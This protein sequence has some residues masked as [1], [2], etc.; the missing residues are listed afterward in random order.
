MKRCTE[1]VFSLALLGVLGIATSQCVT[2]HEALEKK[3][4]GSGGV[5]G[6]GSGGKG[7]S[8]SS[9]GTTTTGGSGGSGG[10]YVD[11]PG[12]NVVTFVHG[13]VDEE[14]IAFCFAHD[15]DGVAE[16][17]GSPLPEGGLDYAHSFSLEALDGF[18][19][20]AEAIQP[21]VLGGDLTEYAGLDCAAAVAKA[22]QA[23]ND[24]L[25]EPS[26]VA[27]APA[28]AG[29][30]G[31]AGGDP[32]PSTGGTPGSGG[33]PA[34]PDAP[35][36]RGRALPALPA[37]TLS[38]GLSYL[39][40]AAGCVGGPWFVDA[41]D[42]N[43]CGADYEGQSTL[44]PILVSMSR[45]TTLRLGLQGVHAS[46]ASGQLDL[47]VTPPDTGVDSP[48]VVAPDLVEG[49]I[50]PRPA[51][52]T[53]FRS[54]LGVGDSAFNLELVSDGSAVLSEPW[55]VVLNRGDLDDAVDGENYVIVALGPK[56]GLGLTKWWNAPA[57][58]IVKSDP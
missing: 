2:D 28:S 26:G 49:V 41:E 56:A 45:E 42:D 24:A 40:V 25:P 11:T 51:E 44:V 30:A 23:M 6:G 39:F 20:G 12:R 10:K 57:L 46:R 54:E 7:G 14:R 4:H 21:Y 31:G 27:G 34:V 58:T 22:E 35:V 3:D 16:F 50:A 29:G 15:V 1:R 55:A 17:D 8:V 13:V 5:G 53:Y 9:A 18:D 37:G 36:A 47:R 48:F 43:V 19:F 32:A 52:T 33:A 38:G